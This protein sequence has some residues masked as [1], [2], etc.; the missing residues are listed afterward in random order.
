[1]KKKQTLIFTFRLNHKVNIFLF[2]QLVA[3]YIYSFNIFKYKN[4]WG[5]NVKI[6][7]LFNKNPIVKRIKFLG[8]TLEIRGGK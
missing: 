7:R 4:M 2:H 5:E 8:D 6:K 3:F 1:M